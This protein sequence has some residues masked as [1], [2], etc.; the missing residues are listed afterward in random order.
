MAP[1]AGQTNVM[2][3]AEVRAAEFDLAGAATLLEA[4]SP[5]GDI[6]AWI[7][8]V[9][10]RGLIQATE[11]S[12]AGGSPDSLAPVREA[13]AWLE[14][15]ANGQPGPAEN[16]RLMLQAAAAA[17]QSEREEMRLY[18]DTA[19]RKDALQ[20]AA[21]LPGVPVVPPGETAGDLWLQVHRYDEARR[22]YDEAADPARPSLRILSG[23]GR[24]ARGAKDVPA[25]CTAFRALIDAWQSRSAEP[26][27]VSDARAYVA[28]A[29]EGV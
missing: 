17:A 5:H 22:A 12:R 18:L 16:A 29:C 21:G 23:R 25:A 11:A 15:A 10:V 2:I 28:S 7:A 14:G 13:I 3:Q 24:A 6:F 8:A 4:A 26:A 27:E 20:R 9:Y 19:I 1:P